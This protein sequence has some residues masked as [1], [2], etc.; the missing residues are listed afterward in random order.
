M[1]NI[2]E[3]EIRLARHRLPIH[4]KIGADNFVSAELN[5]SNAF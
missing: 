5:N 1:S 3:K 4:K 2:A